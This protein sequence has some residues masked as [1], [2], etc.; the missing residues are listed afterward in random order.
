VGVR[1]DTTVAL[2]LALTKDGPPFEP[3][4]ASPEQLAIQ[5][6]KADEQ[7]SYLVLGPGKE[8]DVSVTGK[9]DSN[10]RAYLR[11]YRG[12]L[13]ISD[14]NSMGP[15]SPSRLDLPLQ[16]GRNAFTIG[17]AGGRLVQKR[18][19]TAAMEPAR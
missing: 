6:P 10:T 3:L 7:H 13:Q 4:W 18:D 17:E 14:M 5:S 19:G 8:G 2:T 15:T 1:N 11:V 12:D 9:F 16:P